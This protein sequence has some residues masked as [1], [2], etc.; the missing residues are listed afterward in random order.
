[1]TT[2]RLTRDLDEAMLGGVLAGVAARYGWDVTL[3]RIVAVLVTVA[4]V[5]LPGVILYLAAW[6]IVPR[7]GAPPAGVTTEA[8]A[9]ETAAGTAPVP[10]PPETTDA[11]DAP[12][13]PAATRDGPSAVAG[14][15][16]EA[17]RD[18]ADRLGEAATIAAEAARQAANEIGDVARRPRGAAVEESQAAQTPGAPVAVEEEAPERETESGR[19]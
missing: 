19:A 6:L 1:M 11:P 4:T 5:G 13:A 7:P 15:V 14:E 9:A 17:L 10:A 8:G 2:S 16:A 18:A 12:D 3:L